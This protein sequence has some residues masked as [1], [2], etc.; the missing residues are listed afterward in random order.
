MR[1]RHII[2][3]V[4]LGGLLLSASADL[5]AKE[6]DG[7]GKMSAMQILDRTASRMKQDGGICASFTTTTFQGTVPSEVINGKISILGEKYVMQTP[8]MSTWFDGTHQWNLIEENKEVSVTEPT[9][10]ELQVSSPTAFM[11]MYKQGFNLSV[12]TAS[13][14]G[15]QVWEVTLRPKKRKQEPSTIVLSIDK[16]TFY[17]MCLRIRNEGNWTRISI[18]NFKTSCHLSDKDF[19]FPAK[20]YPQYEVI[21]Y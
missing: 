17:P 19:A 20:D 16:Q 7:D 1:L 13:L 18:D 11:S 15:K 8:F 2:K 6:N 14:R 3:A 4:L 9:Q 5:T 21:E 10:E 12:K